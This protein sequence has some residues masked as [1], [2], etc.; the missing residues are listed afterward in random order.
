MLLCLITSVVNLEFSTFWSFVR[1][2]GSSKLFAYLWQKFI[3]QINFKTNLLPFEVQN[4]NVEVICIY[5]LNYS[6]FFFLI[7]MTTVNEEKKKK[8][9]KKSIESFCLAWNS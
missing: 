9:K 8:K 7:K 2:L 3:Y 4:C 6:I 1:A 5:P